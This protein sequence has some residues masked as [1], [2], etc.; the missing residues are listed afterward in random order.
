MNQNCAHDL[1]IYL[2]D[3]LR[4]TSSGKLP[5][6]VKIRCIPDLPEFSAYDSVEIYEAAQYLHNKRLITLS[7]DGLSASSLAVP[8]QH[9]AVPAPSEPAPKWF[10]VK[11]VT[12]AGQDY[13]AEL[14]DNTLWHKLLEKF[15]DSALE[16]VLSVPAA[17]LL[18]LLQ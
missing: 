18:K 14:R 2:M 1:L 6:P 17:L 4:P 10:V 8:N 7:T 13:C 15:G 5:R 11:Q 12:A 9:F 3:H 16:Q